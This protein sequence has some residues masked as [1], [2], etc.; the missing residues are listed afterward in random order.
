MGC[1]GHPNHRH[2]YLERVSAAAIVDKTIIYIYIYILVYSTILP[3]SI[4]T[5]TLVYYNEK[6]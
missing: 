2:H 5:R 4:L 3:Q 1:G 6:N